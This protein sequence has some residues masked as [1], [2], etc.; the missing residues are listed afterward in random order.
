MEHKQGDVVKLLLARGTH[1]TTLS[2]ALCLASCKGYG[3][4]VGQLVKCGADVN[5]PEASGR[6][7]LQVRGTTAVPCGNVAWVLRLASFPQAIDAEEG[8]AHVRVL[9]VS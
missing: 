6:T 5:T 8:S 1:Q 2:S 7:P 9:V 3:E 4:I